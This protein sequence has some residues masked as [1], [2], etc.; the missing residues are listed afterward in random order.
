MNNLSQH[1]PSVSTK[2]LTLTGVMTAVLCLLGPVAIPLPVSPVPI[3]FT[4]LAIYLA[5]YILGTKFGTVS[6]ALY[7]FLGTI[8][9]P[10]FSGFSGGPAKL[11][12]PTGGYLMGFLFMALIAGFF[13]Q[14]FSGK[15]IPSIAGMGIGTAV[16]YLLG[17][18][19]LAGQMNLTFTAALAIGVMPYLAGDI[20]KIIIA[21]LLGPKLKHAVTQLSYWSR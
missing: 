21:A 12:G 2:S 8:G 14:T 17:T 4:N 18:F 5:V 20:V 1:G 19:W 16:C 3:S 11:A 6:C 13:I 9:L 7:L 15:L 10:V